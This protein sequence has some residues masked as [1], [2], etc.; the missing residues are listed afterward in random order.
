VFLAEQI[1]LLHD[2]KIVQSGSYR[3]LLLRPADPFVTA[4]INAQ[5]A[6]PEAAGVA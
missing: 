6:V 1:T 3:D 2:G 5:R 4:F